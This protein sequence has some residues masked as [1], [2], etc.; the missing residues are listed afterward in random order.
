LGMLAVGA[1]FAFVLYF[2]WSGGKVGGGLA[3]GLRFLLGG[4]AY[5]V[6]IA[7]LASGAILVL[8]PVL[9]SMRPFR[10][11]WTCLLLALSLGLAARPGRSTTPRRSWPAAS[12][13]ATAAA[14]DGTTPAAKPRRPTWS[15]SS[16]PRTS[17]PRRSTREMRVRLARSPSARRPIPPPRPAR[18]RDR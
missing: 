8:R 13:R 11:G 1:F 5:V 4:V 14:A 12:P 7:L 2:G 6:P 10:A 9:P 18:A 15:P 3:V 17:R 16:G